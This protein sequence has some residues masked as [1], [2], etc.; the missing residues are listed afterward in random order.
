MLNERLIEDL[1]EVASSHSCHCLPTQWMP[2]FEPRPMPEVCE[3]FNNYVKCRWPVHVFHVDPA[4]QE[5][6]IADE[7]S[8]RRELQLSL[9]VAVSTGQ[10]NVSEALQF[11]RKLELDMNTI[12]VNRTVV[13]FS[14][15]EDT[16]GYRFQPRIQT[17]DTESNLKVAFRENL[18][19][20]PNR[21]ELIRNYRIE[22]GIRECTA[23]VIAPAFIRQYIVDVH[24][25][26]FDLALAI[27]H[28]SIATPRCPLRWLSI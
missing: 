6:N 8:S 9:A 17:P 14:H 4:N 2:F 25:D 26:W 1:K 11:Q 21:D 7:F 10:L 19:G 23:L 16:F 18:L 24:S 13:G 20:G 15:G 5:Q 22:P 27:R 3:T 12:A 28:S